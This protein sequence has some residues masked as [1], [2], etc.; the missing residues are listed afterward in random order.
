MW[1]RALVGCATLA[2]AVACSTVDLGESPVAP[3]KC[4]PSREYFDTVLWPEY[5]ATSDGDSCASAGCHRI[6]NGRSSLRF[7]IDPVDLDTNYQV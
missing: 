3:G 1:K 5:L 2:S 7:A 6:S 4:Q